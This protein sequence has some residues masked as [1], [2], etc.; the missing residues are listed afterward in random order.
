MH[1]T[2]M[3]RIETDTLIRQLVGDVDTVAFD[4]VGSSA[5]FGGARSDTLWILKVNGER[6]C[7]YVHA[8]LDETFPSYRVI[9]VTPEKSLQGRVWTCS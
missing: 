7:V 8:V 2:L 4:S 5:E 3:K 9:S 1:N 6:G